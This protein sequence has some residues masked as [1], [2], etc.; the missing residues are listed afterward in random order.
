MH[1]RTLPS[2]LPSLGPATRYA[3]F[4]DVGG[5]ECL[6]TAQDW[7]RDLP[8]ITSQR[9]AGAALRSGASR[10]VPGD[11]LTALRD[12]SFASTE[13]AAL[14]SRRSAPALLALQSAGI[15][16]LIIKGPSLS[17]REGGLGSRPYSDID[18]LVRVTEFRRALDVLA[19]EGFSEDAES[20]PPREY[21]NYLCREAVNLRD[22]RGGSVDL[23]H[24]V[25]PWLWS[26]RLTLDELMR[27]AAPGNVAGVHAPFASDI[28]NLLIGALHIVSD[29][30]A[31]GASLRTWRDV[32]LLWE[33]LD[34]DEVLRRAEYCLLTAWLAW[35]L[36]SLPLGTVN[37]APLDGKVPRPI[38][39]KVR[40]RMLL[41]LGGP[42]GRHV[43]LIFRL[44]LR[45]AIA[46]AAGMVVPNKEFLRRRGITS[47]V[48][49]VSWWL[50]GLVAL[51][52]AVA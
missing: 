30:G 42:S 35:I 28:D 19:A 37:L 43:G 36:G 20:R 50:H 6:P 11:V 27:W 48:P 33:R 31:P 34:K 38:H 47:R 25:S 40:L 21:F 39:A 8:V 18:V 44:P 3:M 51:R 45:G 1:R 17:E 2:L 29:Q 22:S 41:W 4:A 5:S 7:R 10:N 14:T 32:A 12:S 16:F 52:R 24:R 26:S 9:L 15:P 46:Y 23:H 13:I 49:H